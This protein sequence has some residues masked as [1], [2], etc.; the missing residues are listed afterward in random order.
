MN[1]LHHVLIY[2]CQHKLRK[3]K[4]IFQGP[5]YRKYS[6]DATNTFHV[7][8][9]LGQLE[10]RSKLRII[11]RLAEDPVVL[12]S[13]QC[14]QLLLCVLVCECVSADEMETLMPQTRPMI[15]QILQ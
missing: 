1:Y 11:W 3:R 6:K 9:N 10:I 7:G 14:I 15:L 13:R 4:E 8:Q 12:K 2:K 5:P